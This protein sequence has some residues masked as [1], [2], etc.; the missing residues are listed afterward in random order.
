MKSIIQICLIF[1]VTL[2]MTGCGSFISAKKTPVCNIKLTTNCCLYFPPGGNVGKK[3]GQI[4]FKMTGTVT[5]G[6]AY[7]KFEKL[8]SSGWVPFDV[9][10]LFYNGDWTPC[11][12]P[13]STTPPMP[14]QKYQISL[15]NGPGPGATS[16]ANDPTGTVFPYIFDSYLWEKCTGD[17]RQ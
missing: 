13:S 4:N 12:P 10:K 7:L 14:A 6:T 5:G 17:G 1:G 8:T 9:P 15:V 16:L 11:F 3:N 2:L